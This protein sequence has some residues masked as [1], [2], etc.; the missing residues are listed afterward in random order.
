MLIYKEFIEKLKE[1]KTLDNP[2]FLNYLLNDWIVI[3]GCDKF[4]DMSSAFSNTYPYYEGVLEDLIHDLITYGIEKVQ[5][6]LN[7]D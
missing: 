2:E 6:R 4:E 5:Y 1:S 7:L 3:L